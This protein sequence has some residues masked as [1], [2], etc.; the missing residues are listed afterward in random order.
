M[1]NKVKGISME[2]GD[3]EQA[4]RAEISALPSFLL[5]ITL[6]MISRDILRLLLLAQCLHALNYKEY[7]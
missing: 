2:N 4:K 7:S 5:F 1:H 3:F 6:N